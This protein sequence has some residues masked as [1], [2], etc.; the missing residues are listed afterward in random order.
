MLRRCDTCEVDEDTA[1][2]CCWNCGNAWTT[3][4]SILH[5]PVGQGAT[6]RG[7]LNPTERAEMLAAGYRGLL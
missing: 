3:I 1:A 7:G 2:G 6:R 5:S 4:G